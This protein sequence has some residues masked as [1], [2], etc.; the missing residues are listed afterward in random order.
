MTSE[1]RHP[2]VKSTLACQDHINTS[3]YNSH[4]IPC[5]LFR[6]CRYNSFDVLCC[7]E[8]EIFSGN[9][10]SVMAARGCIDLYTCPSTSE[11]HH[12]TS[13]LVFSYSLTSSL[14]AKSIFFND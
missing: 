6:G 10:F 4:Y 5:P 9:D 3:R 13:K 1:H 2:K 14:G 11:I 7:M 8:S 12:T